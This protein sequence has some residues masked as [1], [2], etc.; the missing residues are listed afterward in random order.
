MRLFRRKPQRP[1]VTFVDDFDGSPLP[2][3]AVRAGMLI[4]ETDYT[5]SEGGLMRIRVRRRNASMRWDEQK[6][7]P[8]WTNVEGE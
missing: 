5:H 7:I 3:W 6:P 8:Q 2:V 4:V 1:E